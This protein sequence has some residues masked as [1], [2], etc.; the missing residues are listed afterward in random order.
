MFVL[1]FFFFSFCLQLPSTEST[2]FELSL[3][4]DTGPVICNGMCTFICNSNAD[5]K[6]VE[7]ICCCLPCKE[8]RS[9]FSAERCS[10][11]FIVCS[12][13]KMGW[14]TPGERNNA[15]KCFFKERRREM[16]ALCTNAHLTSFLKHILVQEF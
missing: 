2:S 10:T 11:T 6:S 8:V 14:A 15:E 5:L 16:Q 13:K 4:N 1:F 3:G 12:A 7:H 9:F